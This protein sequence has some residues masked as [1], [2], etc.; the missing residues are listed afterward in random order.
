MVSE[1]V[2]LSSDIGWYRPD[3]KVGTFY[4]M[5]TTGATQ[6][7]AGRPMSAFVADVDNRIVTFSTA[8]DVWVSAGQG[9]ASHATA[10][11]NCPAVCSN[12]NQQ[13]LNVNTNN[14]NNANVGLNWDDNQDA[15]TQFTSS[16]SN[17]RCSPTAFNGNCQ[18][19]I[20][21]CRCTDTTYY[22]YNQDTERLHAWTKLRGRT[23]QQGFSSAWEYQQ[24]ANKR[25][26][27]MVSSAAVINTPAVAWAS[28]ALET[29]GLAWERTDGA[30]LT[31]C[32]KRVKDCLVTQG[33]HAQDDGRGVVDDWDA[34]RYDPLE[35]VLGS[36]GVTSI[37]VP[38]GKDSCPFAL[39]GDCDTPGNADQS[40]KL[41]TDTTDCLKPQRGEQ[42]RPT[43]S[44][45][46]LTWLSPSW[47]SPATRP[48]RGCRTAD[49]CGRRVVLHRE[50]HELGVEQRRV[51]DHRDPVRFDDEG[52][53]WAV[54]SFPYT[55]AHPISDSP[56]RQTGGA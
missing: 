49:S 46:A 13:K 5:D 45:L 44:Q 33:T 16:N 51:S 32:Q 55:P 27:D 9:Y 36:N 37:Y 26:V 42:V 2:V 14:A 12:H 41:G 22:E 23:S 10:K 31:S 24:V 35:A 11:A 17:W 21:S 38:L 6:Y 29:A 1:W 43:D 40:C 28:T 20:A 53:P 47:L 25:L 54:P 48:P 52:E 18:Q 39:D 34:C 56:Y 50:G 4:A 3:I 19:G 7:F 8:M 30:P 15:A